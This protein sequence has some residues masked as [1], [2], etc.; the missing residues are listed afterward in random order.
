MKEKQSGKLE[1][2]K[3]TMKALLTSTIHKT[4]QNSFSPSSFQF[5]KPV[6]A[7]QIARFLNI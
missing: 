5:D 3:G 2:L 6:Q 4:Q 7:L 1:G